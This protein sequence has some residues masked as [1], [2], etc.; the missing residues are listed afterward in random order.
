VVAD[1]WIHANPDV[2]RYESTTKL[3]EIFLRVDGAIR[4]SA[5]SSSMGLGSL[6]GP[7]VMD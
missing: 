5:A 4:G 7:S 3:N 6:A 2:I 1:Y